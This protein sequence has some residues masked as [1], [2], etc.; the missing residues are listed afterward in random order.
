MREKAK[1]RLKTQFLNIPL[2]I[3]QYILSTEWGRVAKGNVFF[4]PGEDQVLPTIPK[5]RRK[6]KTSAQ[7]KKS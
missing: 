5:L 6:K 4:L 3:S 7:R 2:P 1:I